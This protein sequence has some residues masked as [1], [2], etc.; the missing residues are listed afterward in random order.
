MGGSDSK[1][2]AGPAFDVSISN[3]LLQSLAENARASDNRHVNGNNDAQSIEQWRSENAKASVV[4]DAKIADLVAGIDGRLD[5]G[6]LRVEKMNAIVAQNPS[7]SGEVP[8]GDIQKKL[9]DAMTVHAGM[10][11]VQDYATKLKVCVREALA[12]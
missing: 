12:Q 6:K 1:P 5:D 8:C 3:D 11:T 7:L 2:S 10:E 9:V 4:A